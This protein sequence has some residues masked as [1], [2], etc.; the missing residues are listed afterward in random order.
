[1]IHHSIHVQVKADFPSSDPPCALVIRCPNAGP[2]G[3]KEVPARNP[4]P[5]LGWPQHVGSGSQIR[6]IQARHFLGNQQRL[7][8]LLVAISSIYIHMKLG[9]LVNLYHQNWQWETL[10]APIPW[11]VSGIWKRRMTRSQI[12]LSRCSKVVRTSCSAKYL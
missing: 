5:R 9:S 6:M 1:M 2:R 3:T 4:S 12:I 8:L 7:G 11:F 10:Q